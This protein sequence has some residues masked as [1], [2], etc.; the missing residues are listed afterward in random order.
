MR[1]A[2]IKEYEIENGLNVGTSLFVQGCHFHCKG[3][4]NAETWDFKGG[5]EWSIEIENKW[6]KHISLPYIKRVSILGG[7]PLAPENIE[8][9]KHLLQRIRSEMPNKELWLYTGNLFENVSADIKELCDVI[10]DGQFI[11]EQ[12]S[13]LLNFRG[14]ENQRVIYCKGDKN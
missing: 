13:K 8:T 10:V 12:S 14:S 1:F 11:E 9:V 3:C 4:F 7:E 5:E 2:R 6:L